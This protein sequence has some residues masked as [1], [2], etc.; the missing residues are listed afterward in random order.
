MSHPSFISLLLSRRAALQFERTNNQ[1]LRAMKNSLPA[2]IVALGL[3]AT[4]LLVATGC[5]SLYNATMENVFGY[6]K[7]ELF[8]KSVTALQKDQ[9]GA[10]EEF[11]DA[12]T[13]LQELYGFKGGDLEAIYQKVKTSYERCESDAKAVSSRIKTME[14]LA[15]DMFREWE[16]EI[17]QYSNPTL[18]ANSRDQMRA[19]KERYAQLSKTVRAA[20]AAMHP[21]LTQLKDNVLFLKHNLNAAAIGSLQGEATN[22][23]K[24]ILQLLSRMNASIAESD[25]FIQS[26]NQ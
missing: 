4:A 18:A 11:K 16:K 12:L 22:I 26:L 2:R 24:Q 6:E 10:Q 5:R 19:T 8:K 25:R 23:Q 15:A 7:R 9:Q 13:R 3:L 21:V 14:D 1:T 17:A 20:E